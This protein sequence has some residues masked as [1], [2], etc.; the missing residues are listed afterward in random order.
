M[1]PGGSGQGVA[2][3][4]QSALALRLRGPDEGVAFAFLVLDEIRVDRSVEARIVQLGREIVAL[5]RG[6]FRPGGAD[7]R[8]ADE[9]PMAWRVFVGPVGLGG[10]ADI[11]G[12]IVELRVTIWPRN[13]APDF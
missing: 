11:F 2:D 9:D 4:S 7:F 12:L 6:M 13:S 1:P 5:L 8:A 3:G 10:D